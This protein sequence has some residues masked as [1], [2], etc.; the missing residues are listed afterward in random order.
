M[1]RINDQ[2][3]DSVFYLYPSVDEAER[4]EKVGGAG[5]FVYVPSDVHPNYGFVYAVTNKHVIENPQAPSP[6]IRLNTSEDTHDTIPLTVQHWIPHQ[7]GDDLSVA[8]L[9]GVSPVKYKYRAIQTFRFLT[10]DVL[11]AFDIGPGDDVYMVGRFSSYEG[12]KRNLPSVRWGI[13]S[14]MPHDDEGVRFEQGGFKQEAFV[15][16]MRSISGYSGSPV[17]FQFPLALRKHIEQ[18]RRLTP[19]GW[20]MNVGPWLL[21]IDCGHFPLYDAVRE[22]RSPGDKSPY[23]KTDYVAKSHSGFAIVIPAWK[24][25][26]LLDLEVFVMARKEANERLARQ[27]ENSEVELDVLTPEDEGLT[28][29]EFEEALRRASRKTSTAEEEEGET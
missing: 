26:E 21:G 1:P 6:V 18:S 15:V 14:V 13:I 28:V 16:E 29:G 10:K 9:G 2:V 22:K 24:L 12:E 7:D 11:K 25:Q 23:G 20:Q 3:L 17:I 27:M 19:E 8:Q 5:F 4:G